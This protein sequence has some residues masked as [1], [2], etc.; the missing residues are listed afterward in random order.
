MQ[1]ASSVLLLIG[2]ISEDLLK[3]LDKRISSPLEPQVKEAGEA[4][5]LHS[6]GDP[7]VL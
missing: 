4:S 6:G 3:D 7:K 5:S 1:S 2:D